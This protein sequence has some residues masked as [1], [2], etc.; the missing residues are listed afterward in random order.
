MD[1][2]YVIRDLT[3]IGDIDGN[4]AKTIRW[5]RRRVYLNNNKDEIRLCDAANDETD[6]YEYSGSSAGIVTNKGC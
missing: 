5:N 3:S 6:S 1:E 4:E 2:S